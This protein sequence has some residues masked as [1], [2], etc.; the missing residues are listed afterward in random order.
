[1]DTAGRLGQQLNEFRSRYLP[2]GAQVYLRVKTFFFNNFYF[3]FMT[4]EAL[5][6]V[7]NY[8]Y[9]VQPGI[10]SSEAATRKTNFICND[11]WRRVQFLKGNVSAAL[12]D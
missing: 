10:H 5:N 12:T 2:V 6:V 4:D 9:G 8:F 3:K 7:E 1:M 11:V